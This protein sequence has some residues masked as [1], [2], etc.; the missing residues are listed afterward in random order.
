MAFEKIL[1]TKTILQYLKVTIDGSEIVR[2][3]IFSIEVS[4]NFDEFG[5]T[6][7]IKLR[8]TFDLNNNGRFLL[9]GNNVLVIS[10]SDYLGVKSTRTYRI[11]NTK[12]TPSQERFKIYDFDFIDEI[13]FQLQNSFISKSF[14]STPVAA[15]QAYLA[16]LGIDDLLSADN[17]ETDIEDTSTSSNFV[18]PQNMSVLDFFTEELKTENIR[19]W[20][21]RFGL[22]VKELVL[23]DLVPYNTNG[24]IILY[25]NKTTNN[26]YLY[27]IHDYDERKNATEITNNQKPVQ[28]VFR[29]STDKEIASITT[30]LADIIDDIKMNTLD[31]SSLQLT[32]GEKFDTQSTFSTG[33]QDYEL[34]DVYTKN[35]QIHI[36]CGGSIRTSNIGTVAMLELKGSTVSPDSVMKGDVLTSGKYFLGNVTDKIIGD[37]LIHRLSMYRIDARTPR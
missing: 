29:H 25:T 2:D 28:R 17:L 32:T 19:I 15:F 8:D 33:N 9:N 11:I 13:T 3:D 22:H 31:A 14:N 34:F 26:E 5:L 16:E 23:S 20:Q 7:T 6:G 27:K 37:K 35:N 21:D 18:V 24:E 12:I 10:L 1:N 36:A 30:N 4:Q